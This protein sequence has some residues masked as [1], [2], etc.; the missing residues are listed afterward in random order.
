MA[1]MRYVGPFKNEVVEKIGL[2]SGAFDILEKW[3]KVQGLW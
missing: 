3:L 1:V 2:L